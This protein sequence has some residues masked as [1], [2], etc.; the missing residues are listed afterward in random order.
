[1][2]GVCGGNTT[3]LA[4]S[5]QTLTLAQ[6]GEWAKAA[7]NTILSVVLCLL[8]VWLGHSTAAA[9]NRV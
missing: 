8:A 9:L 3:F 5:L 7:L 4:F 1:M 6:G 2:V